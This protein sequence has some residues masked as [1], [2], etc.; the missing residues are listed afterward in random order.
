MGDD[1]TPVLVT[2]ASGYLG[3]SVL[4]MLRRE[5]VNAVG[6]SRNAPGT[7]TCDLT[8][9]NAVQALLRE[10]RPRT[11]VHCAANVPRSA[12]DYLDDD[13]ARASLLM[14]ENL[15][16]HRPEY[17][18]FASSMT[19]YP[20]G[21]GLAREDCANPNS[22][23]YAGGKLRAERLLF[24]TPGVT[25]TILRLPGL[26]GAPRRS[27]VLFNAALAF[28]FGRMPEL[29]DRLPQWSALHISDAA[30]LLVRA[31]RRKPAASALMNAG[32]PGRMSIRSAVKCIAA[33][34]DRDFD[35]GNP[36]WFEFDLDVLMSTLGLPRVTFEFR[37]AEFVEWVRVV[38]RES[39]PARPS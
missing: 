10:I 6:V 38:A 29:N 13:A 25:S 1:L 35:I 37:I 24:A 36:V 22:A 33:C 16:R 5:G 11:V 3:G 19:V 30:E 34:F 21:I 28:V 32:Y 17:L 2:G 8:D 39:A 20:D 27:G 9:T 12:A 15:V 23:G 14:V 4:E 31:V 26:F 18:V 7:I